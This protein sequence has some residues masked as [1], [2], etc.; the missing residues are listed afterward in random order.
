MLFPPDHVGDSAGENALAGISPVWKG[1]RVHAGE[2]RKLYSGELAGRNPLPFRF[3]GERSEE[4]GEDV[5]IPDYG[6][7]VAVE[8]RSD[9]L[10]NHAQSEVR[11]KANGSA[12]S[13]RI[14]PL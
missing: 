2:S 9:C 6:E 14:F 8:G 11:M 1:E 5:K 13:L 10:Q 3:R 12:S 4:G 7:A